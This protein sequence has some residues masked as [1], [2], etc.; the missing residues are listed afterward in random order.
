[1]DAPLWIATNSG[2]LEVDP[3]NSCLT[4]PGSPIPG[5]FQGQAGWGL[6]QPGLVGSG[7]WQRDWKIFKVFLNP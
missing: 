4:I 1:M 3:M 2:M 6:D 7:P 5:S